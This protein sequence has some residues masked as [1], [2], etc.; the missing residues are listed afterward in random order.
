[1]KNK[2]LCLIGLL[3]F[4]MLLGCAKKEQADVN[5]VTNIPLSGIFATYGESI[6]NGAML[7]LDEI[8]TQGRPGKTKLSFTWSDNA[9][10]PNQTVSLFQKHI[11]NPIDIYISGV[12][13]QTM[14]IIDQVE[15]HGLPHFVWIFDA[16]ACQNRE[17]IFRTWVSYKYEPEQY[18]K[19][20]RHKAPKRIAITY[21]NLPHVTEEMTD[22]MLPG[23]TEMGYSM[24]DGDIL[25]E[26]YNWEQR[27][28]KNIVAKLKSF[29][30]DLILLNGFQGNLVSLVKTLRENGMIEDG[31][32][33][34]TYDMLDAA[35]LLSPDELEGIRLIVPKF[36]SRSGETN[37]I[38]WKER[39]ITKYN[40]PP[41]YTDAYAYD[42]TMIINDAAN[43]IELPAT[44]EEWIRALQSIKLVGVTGNLEFDKDGDLKADLDIAVYRNGELVPDYSVK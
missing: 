25:I 37:I 31:N 28:F 23:L 5:I 26:V 7:A 38:A 2:K 14:S 24:D 6:Q 8:T 44:S 39:F 21:V 35:E 43:R 10:K 29:N 3:A 32:V 22:I 36:N 16:F 40:T 30:P 12:K 41:L 20:I 19:Y 18:L 34:A 27:D 11:L 17:S 1:M 13:P 4:G 33:I 15:S 9:G 42:M